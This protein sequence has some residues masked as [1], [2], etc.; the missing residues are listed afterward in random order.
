MEL[1]PDVFTADYAG[2]PGHRTFYIQARV[3]SSVMTY[4]LEKGQVSVLAEKLGEMLLAID[5]ED[6][7]KGATPARDP[8]LLAEAQEPA[9]RVGSMG[10]GYDPD[11]DRIMVVLNEIEPDEDDPEPAGSV[12]FS[13]RTD[14]AR[15]FILHATAVVA[16]GRPTCPLC[17]L[18]MDAEGHRCPASN[19]HHPVE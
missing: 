6:T 15:S 2:E 16:E 19:G 14:Q 4:L 13:L 8:A 5:P 12:E 11:A 10:L 17:G 9:W 1:S 7:I 3:G 18:P